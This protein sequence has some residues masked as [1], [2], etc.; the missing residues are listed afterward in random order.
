MAQNDGSEAAF[1][2]RAKGTKLQQVR[3]SIRNLLQRT[4]IRNLLQN[5]IHKQT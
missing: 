2:Y 4:V 1:P 5:Y 3:V